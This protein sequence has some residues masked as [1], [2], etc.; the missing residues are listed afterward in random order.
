MF[1]LNSKHL[2]VCPKFSVFGNVVKH[3]LSCFIYYFTILAVKPPRP[4]FGTSVNQPWGGYGFIL[5]LYVSFNKKV[6]INSLS[7]NLLFI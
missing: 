2:E 7:S 6:L 1:D 5:Q 4:S 3:S